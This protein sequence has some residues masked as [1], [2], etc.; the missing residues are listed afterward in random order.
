MT[1]IILRCYSVAMLIVAASM[2]SGNASAQHMSLVSANPPWVVPN[3]GELAV[4]L[5]GSGLDSVTGVRF[6]KSGSIDAGGIEVKRISAVG[7]H[8]LIALIVVA[9]DVT[10][11]TYDVELEAAGVSAKSPNVFAVRNWIRHSFSCTGVEVWRQR[12][13]CRRGY[14]QQ[15]LEGQ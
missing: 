1:Q 9:N 5:I 8:Q 11:G 7:P 12:R 10:A 3:S 15:F 6:I 13:S 2:L 14:V 4:T